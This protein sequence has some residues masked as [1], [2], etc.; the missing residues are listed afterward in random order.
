MAEEE[1]MMEDD[2]IALEDSADSGE[3]DIEITNA[4]SFV[5]DRKIKSIY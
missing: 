4:V 2:A 3:T 5:Y 1:I